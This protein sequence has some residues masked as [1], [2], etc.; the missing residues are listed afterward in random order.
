MAVTADFNVST[1]IAKMKQGGALA[2]LFSAVLEGV[3][4]QVSTKQWADDLMF[5]C[6]AASFPASTIEATT[7]SYMGREINIPGN[8]A[9]A[10]WTT[11]IYND[12]DFGLRNMLEEWM[13]YLNGHSNNKRNS[14][15]I[16]IDKYTATLQV[17][18]FPKSGDSSTKSYKFHNAWPS[19]IGEITTD[20]DTNDLQEYEVSWEFSHWGSADSGAG[21]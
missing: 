11:T 4:S 13:E 16:G 20:W 19:E 18:Q 2:S 5:Y 6:K 7:I 17:H 10:Q 8:R 21:E 12:E 9:A 14:E 3:P 1:W 15:M